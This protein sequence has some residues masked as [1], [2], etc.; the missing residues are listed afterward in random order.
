MTSDKLIGEKTGFDVANKV[1]D[2]LRLYYVYYHG[3]N[4]RPC[5]MTKGEVN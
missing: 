3:L 2:S 5:V 1:T 4:V